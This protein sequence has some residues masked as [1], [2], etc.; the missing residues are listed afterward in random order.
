MMLALIL[1]VCVSLLTISRM[2]SRWTGRN[3]LYHCIVSIY[4][5]YST[6]HAQ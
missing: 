5:P 1:D 4:V 2:A 6:T 3:R